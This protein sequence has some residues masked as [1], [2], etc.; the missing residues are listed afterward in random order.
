V[1]DEDPV[2]VSEVLILLPDK[3]PAAMQ[4]AFTVFR[5]DAPKLFID[6][7]RKACLQQGIEMSEVFQTLQVFLGSR[8]VNDFNLFD[9]SWQVVV[10]ADSKFRDNLED[11]KSLKVRNRRGQMVP[12]G[13]V[14]QVQERPGPLVLTRYNMYPAA[15]INGS[16]AQG[17]SSSAAREMIE[18]LADRELAPGM[19]AEWTEIFYVE[20]MSGNTGM[21]VFGFSV[22]FVFLVLAAQYESWTLPLAVI[23][24][25]P[26]CVLCSLV[27]VW[28]A[29]HDINIFTQ[30][31]F[32]VLIGL[33]CKN[34]ILIVEFAKVKR[35]EGK[36]A[37]DATLEACRLRLRP[38]FM[39][40]FAF[41]L[42]VV[43]LVLAHGAGAEMRE[44]LGTAVFAG[45]LGVTLFGIF[46]TPIFFF[47]IDHVMHWKVFNSPLVVGIN[48]VSMDLL[49][50][51]WVWRLFRRN[52]PLVK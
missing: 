3:R 42:G 40:S 32:V 11:V 29:E 44:V 27:G 45:M 20:K 7:N 47:V 35:E 15:A 6:I 46:L 41:I 31:G 37:R 16:A 18:S 21:I 17:V 39:T 12:L 43:P 2:R 24:V 8:Y 22:V 28:L 4:G 25:V 1:N 23:L 19:G 38:I 30:V 14:A 9:R 26:M 51:R 33:A 50:F 49:R 36:S 10:Q 13:S 34:A 48:N 52:T 5:T